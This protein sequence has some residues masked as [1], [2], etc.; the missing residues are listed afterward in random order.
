MKSRSWPEKFRDAFRGVG[1]GARS[2][3]SFQV[4]LVCAIAVSGMAALARLAAWQWC[5]L[6]LCVVTVLVAEMFNTS[7]EVMAKAIDVEYHPH[8]R[9]ALDLASGAVLVAAIGAALVGSIV[10][11]AAML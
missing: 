6:L 2:Q 8:L 3:N 10:M 4:H 9:D 7:L 11:A 1:I 5:I